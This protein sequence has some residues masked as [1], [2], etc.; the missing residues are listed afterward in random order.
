MLDAFINDINI[1]PKEI[2]IVGS[3]AIK[4][5]LSRDVGDIDF[6]LTKKDSK[7]KLERENRIPTKFFSYH[8]EINQ[9]IDFYPNRYFIIG[10]SD[11]L[12]VKLNYFNV[13]KATKVMIVL[14]EVELAYKL[15]VKR[16]KD[17]M[18]LNFIKDRFHD[19]FNWELVELII[20]RFK[21]KSKL[22]KTILR[23]LNIFR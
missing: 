8:H 12:I 7:K 9:Y 17:S 18:D 15:I 11:K 6:T 20:N 22:N 13:E 2:L 23:F 4:E 1:S 21:I 19:D 5:Y 14:P 10:L 16:E 3:Y